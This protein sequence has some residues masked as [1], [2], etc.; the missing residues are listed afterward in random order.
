[1]EKNKLSLE[2]L[3]SIGLREST[4]EYF[5]RLATGETK[6]KG[7]FIFGPTGAGKTYEAKKI[8][9]AWEYIH[10]E[11]S[12]FLNCAKDMRRIH[13]KDRYN[14]QG[15]G[16]HSLFEALTSTN[17]QTRVNRRLL[18]LDDF[19]PEFIVNKY[20]YVDLYAI[21]DYYAG[22]NLPLVVTSNY[23]LDDLA[24]SE[25]VGER[26][27]SRIIGVCNILKLDGDDLRS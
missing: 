1:M 11:P 7:F 5:K 17:P 22:N 20:Q 24:K 23:T 16:M 3:K 2:E 8:A 26:I 13:E 6:K 21:I 9:E 12:F 19:A 15:G 4:I 14:E 18:I 10:N 27:V 25:M